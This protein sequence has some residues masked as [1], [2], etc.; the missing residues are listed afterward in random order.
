M[1]IK[2][3]SWFQVFSR[4]FNLVL[5]RQGKEEKLGEIFMGL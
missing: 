1:F 4:S 3:F 2:T 5:I